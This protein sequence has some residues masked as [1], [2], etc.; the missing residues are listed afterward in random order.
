[1]R[2]WAAQLCRSAIV[3][4][5]CGALLGACGKKSGEQANVSQGQ[6]VAHMG[7]EVVTRQ[8]LENEF[9]WA[10][11]PPE[12]QKD[13]AVIRQVLTELVVRKY[14]LQQALAAKLDREPG[15]L[16]DLLRAREQ[17]L[18]NATVMR[19]VASKPPG[20]PEIDRYIASNPAKFANRKLLQVEQIAFPMGPSAQ[21]VVDASRD[22]KS[23][24]EID[25]KL[26]AA[27][28]PHGRQN[29]VLATG[30]LGQD[31]FNAIEARKA[32]DVFYVRSGQGGI[33]FKVK[34]EE[35]RPIEGDAA[36]NLARQLMRADAIKAEIELASYSAKLEAKFEGDYAQIMQQ[37]NKND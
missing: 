30:D 33:F 9:R 23:L 24:D 11:V 31:L 12:R 18:E 1:M 32:D 21:S 19:T 26:T 13:P 16:L 5:C 6:V 4:G 22:A 35:A 7:N 36:T 34:G 37:G 10:N 8:E 29:G 27:A 2:K 25:Q 17:V 15:I 3:V 20:K 14:L 28:I